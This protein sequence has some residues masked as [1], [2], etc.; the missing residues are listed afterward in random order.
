MTT[1]PAMNQNKFFSDNLFWLVIRF[2]VGGIF[3][4]AGFIKLME[5]RA[6]FEAL[7][8]SYPLFPEALHSFAAAV[9][10]WVEWVFGVSLL[11]GY[12][13]VLSSAM[14]GLMSLS[15]LFFIIT[16][17]L[18]AGRGGEDCGCFGKGGIKITVQTELFLDL[19]LIILSG[20]LVWAR[21]FPWSLEE[22]L[23]KG[24][25]ENKG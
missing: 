9:I 21:R 3:S 14:L 1:S 16:G 20:L 2:G 10:P 7:L 22:W 13:P 25:V 12:L 8:S 11:L 6:N 23:K 4:Y 5:P 24:G 18:A 17:P 15:F 19:G